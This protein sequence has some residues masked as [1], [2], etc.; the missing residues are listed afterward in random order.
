MVGPKE[1]LNKVPG[2]DPMAKLAKYIPATIFPQKL[3]I[4]TLQTKL[5]N[6][7][8]NDEKKADDLI[9]SKKFFLIELSFLFI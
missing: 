8:V 9:T 5:D 1:L 3:N 4:R 7:I 6:E 2:N